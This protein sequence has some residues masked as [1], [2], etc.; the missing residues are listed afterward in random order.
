MQLLSLSRSSCVA[1]LKSNDSVQVFFYFSDNWD[2]SEAGVKNCG[3]DIRCEWQHSN[4]ITL[5]R[6]MHKDF[7]KT[8]DLSLTVAIFNIHRFVSNLSQV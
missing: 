8:Q 6:E 5:L 4:N 7:K 1:A 2:S 3:P